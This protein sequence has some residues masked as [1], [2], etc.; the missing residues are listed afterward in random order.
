MAGKPWEKYQT[1]KSSGKPW[2]K[3]QAK[4][5]PAEGN[6]LI[7]SGLRSIPFAGG[8]AGGA[9]GAILAGLPTAG[10]G[11]PEGAVA[12]AAAGGFAG[13]S[14]E[15]ALRAY[16]G[17]PYSDT[18]SKS[19]SQAERIGDAFK[20]SALEAP[21]QAANE[22]GGQAL[23][24][25]LEA[26]FPKVAAKLSNV[27]ERDLKRYANN[28]DQIENIIKQAGP[29]K[30]IASQVDQARAEANQAINNYKSGV[31][32]KIGESLKNSSPDK[33]IDM[34]SILDKIGSVKSQINPTL[35]PE[36]ISGINALNNKISSL[37]G[38]GSK[39]SVNELNDLRNHLQAQ[40]EGQFS[41]VQGPGQYFNPNDPVARAAKAGWQESRSALQSSAP[42]V[43]DS[44]SQLAALRKITKSAQPG[45]LK[46]GGNI[47][48]FINAGRGTNPSNAKTLDMLSELTGTPI[49][50]AA[51]DLSAAQSMNR[52]EVNPLSFWSAG[53]LNNPGAARLAILADKGSSKAL[54][55]LSKYIGRAGVNS[56]AGKTGELSGDALKNYWQLLMSQQPNNYVEA[57]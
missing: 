49:N 32:Q 48:P 5:Q 14:L 45:L 12:G 38:E 39:L 9:G 56:V 16:L 55:G 6:G 36:S 29:D 33:T 47:V 1:Q 3:Y 43:G 37:G 17:S 2:E 23:N 41:K 27:P 8:V 7:E 53:V 57:P 4:P 28:P 34:T 51:K 19:E 24:K 35:D 26:F 22:M 46:E 42:E 54:S 10:I 21:K 13:K 31:N 50:T 20:Q 25:G 11:A 44:L 18:L 52:T 15:N 40:A 30:N